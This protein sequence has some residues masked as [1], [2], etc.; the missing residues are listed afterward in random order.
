MLGLRFVD[1][2]L[3]GSTGSGKG[4][5]CRRV[6]TQSHAQ[7]VFERVGFAIF[8]SIFMVCWKKENSPSWANKLPVL[9]SGL[10]GGFK[11]DFIKSPPPTYVCMCYYV[12]SFP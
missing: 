9:F 5:F 7:A 8:H 10:F 12:C 3:R 2:W 4:S 1:P 6:K 11:V